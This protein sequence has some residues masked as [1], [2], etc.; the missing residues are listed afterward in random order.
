MRDQPA[1]NDP[2]HPQDPAQDAV[3]RAYRDAAAQDDARPSPQA[4]AAV[5]AA[6]ARAVHSGPRP[7]AEPRSR[8]TRYRVPLALAASLLVGT[9]AWQ[10]A[11][12]VD[13]QRA[14]E[15]ASTT[16]SSGTVVADS[17][18]PP[19]R[20]AAEAAPAAASPPAATASPAASE[21]AG[22]PAAP[23]A[24]VEPAAP[25][26]TAA[27]AATAQSAKTAPPPAVSIARDASPDAA[28]GRAA[29]PTALRTDTARADAAPRADVAGAATAAAARQAAESAE[30][31]AVT[32]PAPPPPPAAPLTAAPM[33]PSPPP[34]PPAASPAPPAAAPAPLR[35]APRVEEQVRTQ[36]VERRRFDEPRPLEAWLRQIAELRA[37]GRHVEADEELA[38]LRRAYPD[39]AIP[40]SL[41]SP[42]SR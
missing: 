3:L 4:R 17:G 22:A 39:A 6:A 7:V 26:A 11:A 34:P 13:G 10:M 41:Q 12:Q 23:P 1:M 25:A 37:A 28:A 8:L 42:A 35:G 31:R 21:A 16:A 30:R 40:P 18:A 32:A 20:Q 19:A 36:P 5:L 29:A 38:R 24:P 14:F 2:Q 27:T 9:V 33:P 15:Q